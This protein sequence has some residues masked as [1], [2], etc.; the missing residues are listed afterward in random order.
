MTLGREQPCLRHMS[1]RKF[2]DEND[3]NVH[4]CVLG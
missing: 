2:R 4:I 3:H 1:G